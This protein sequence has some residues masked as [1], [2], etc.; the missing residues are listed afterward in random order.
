MTIKKANSNDH[1]ILTQITKKSKAH[2]GYSNEQIE[3]WSEFLTVSKRIYR[4]KS[5]L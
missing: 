2:W 5:S 3:I 4:N 1:E